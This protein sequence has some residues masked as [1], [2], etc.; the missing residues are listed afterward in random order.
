MSV[1]R[2]RQ[3]I[4][5]SR[6]KIAVEAD[7]LLQTSRHNN[8]LDGITGVLLID[9]D[10]IVQVLEGPDESVSAAFARISRD[11]RHAEIQVLNDRYIDERDFGYWSMEL[12]DRL[13]LK[14]EQ[15]ARLMHRVQ[16]LPAALR[17]FFE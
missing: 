2:L 3:I 16:D 14:P 15:R 13:E 7:A 17:H 5:A 10:A 1:T 11:D 9:G 6:T 8:A 4:Y 12:A